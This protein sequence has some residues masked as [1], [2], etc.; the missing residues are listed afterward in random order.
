VAHH[1]EAGNVHAQIAGDADVL[2]AHVGFGAMGRH[3]DRTHADVI[4][5]AQFLDRADA[6][7]DQRG[8][9]ALVEHFGH[10]FQPFPIGMR[11]KAIV[12]AGADRP[13]PCATSIASTPEASIAAAIARTW[14]IPYM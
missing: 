6:G 14:S 11:A 8:Q 3:A 5:A 9:H 1:Q 10:G 2:L 13:S 7:Q 12:E 4:G